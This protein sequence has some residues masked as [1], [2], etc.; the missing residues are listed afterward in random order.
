MA[1]TAKVTPRGNGNKHAVKKTAFKQQSKPV[2]APVKREEVKA[3]E[4]VE[5]PIAA[6]TKEWVETAEVSEGE[7]IVTAHAAP[8]EAIEDALEVTGGGED[9]GGVGE[10][11]GDIEDTDDGVQVLSPLP[12]TPYELGFQ[13]A[14]RQFQSSDI[15]GLPGVQVGHCFARVTDIPE[16]LDDWMEVNPRVPNRT[17]KGVLSGPVVKG[18][19]STLFNDPTSMALK[20]QGIY[21][22]VKSAVHSDGQVVVN[23]DNRA[24]HGIINGGH[25]YAAIRDAIET[26][27]DEFKSQLRRAYVPLHLLTGVRPES[28]ADIAE[29]LNRNKQVDDA[30]LANLQ[31]LFAPI[32]AVMRDKEDDISYYQGDKGDV[33]ISDVLVF[34][35]MFN[36]E[37]FDENRH[38][39]YLYSRVKSAQEFYLKDLAQTPSPVDLIVP[40]LP[41]ILRLSDQIRKEVPNSAKKQGFEFGRMK[42]GKTAKRA[43]TTQQVPL[44]FLGETMSYKVPDGWLYPMLASFR[45]NVNWDLDSGVFEWKVPLA[46]LLPRVIDRL[47]AVCIA[48]HRQGGQKPDK[49]GKAESAYSQCYD[50]VHLYLLGAD[51]AT[52][53]ALLGATA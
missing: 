49:V 35:E 22:L 31:G 45:A 19:M 47:V 42:T 21:L 12:S 48:E 41:E 50:K 17:G 30:S 46:E 36:P 33:D 26:A 40:H 9:D 20:N 15:P 13:I 10:Y 1:K 4:P 39:S 24:H 8:V 7:V 52:Q 53:G 28:V 51:K 14:A 23:L 34:L 18:I 37:R 2:A 3:Q 11:S 5:E 27:G 25:T 44:P 32:Q 43:K 38:P 16:L 29:G 6:T